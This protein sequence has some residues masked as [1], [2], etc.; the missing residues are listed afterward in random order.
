MKDN[1]NLYD[2]IKELIGTDPGNFSIME[3]NINV[4]LQVEYFEFSKR[5]AEDFDSGWALDQIDTLHDPDFPLKSK[6]QILARLATTD[7][8][9]AYRAI[10]SYNQDPDEELREWGL[11]AMQ[12]SRMHIE[13]D[14]LEENQIFISTGL[15]GKNQKLRYF[16]A[17]IARNRQELTGF[18]VK[19]IRDEFPY[20][21]KKYD[22]E[23]E[24]FNA[25]A[26]LATFL[27]L[28]PIQHSVH[29]VFSEGI[30]ECNQYGDFL[31]DSC[32]VTNVKK[33]SFEEI[34]NFIEQKKKK[35]TNF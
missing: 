5:M 8:V 10:E 24:E 30:E 19:I 32:I 34:F 4:D 16:V 20:I 3:D 25:E 1:E 17:L 12:E 6:K 21:M 28:L 7:N 26:Y 33:L 27:L 29:K 31:R 2:K 35:G 14:L 23:I 18:Q 22:A 15:G 13:S 9:T 11:L